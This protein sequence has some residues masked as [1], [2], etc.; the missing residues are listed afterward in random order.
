MPDK[1]RY[2]EFCLNE[3][4]LPLFFQ[5]WWLDEVCVKGKWDVLLFEKNNQILGVYP[6]FLK[7][8]YKVFSLITMPPFTPFLGPYIKYP[9]NLKFSERSSFEKDVYNFFISTLPEFDMFTQFFNYNFSNWLPFYWQKFKQTTYYS[10]VIED[11][12]V[13]ENVKSNFHSNKIQE[14]EKALKTVK[15]K[16]DLSPEDF[17]SFHKRSLEK[18]NQKISYTVDFFK[19]VVEAAIKN[20]SG[21]IIYASDSEKIYSALFF[22]WD[23]NSGYNLITA[24]DPDLKK[25]GSLSLLIFQTIDFLSSKAGMY[26]LE[27]SMNENYEFSYRK[28]GGKQ[29]Q[30][31]YLTKTNSFLLKINETIRNF[32]I[33]S[34][35][36]S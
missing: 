17:Y 28:F 8:K 7:K 34:S 14:I 5:P 23:K 3:T 22:I 4:K 13:I 6:F 20:N 33:D 19:N 21:R 11:I 35:G 16:F 18:Q 24:N 26:D 30:Y 29:Q 10:Y 2:R 27:G 31:F 9:E 25:Y 36:N 15:I 32:S 12:S 1:E